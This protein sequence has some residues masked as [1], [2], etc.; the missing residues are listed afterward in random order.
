MAHILGISG[1]PRRLGITERML[2]RA[3]DGARSA[4]AGVEKIILNEL[5]FKPCQECG[6]CTETGACEL[7]DD[8]KGVYKKFDE[9]DGFIIAS[10]I[11]FGS[12]S[13][14]LKMMI[15]R[16]Q[17]A[18]ARKYVLKAPPPYKKRR[19][20][21]FICVGGQDTKEYFENAKQIVKLMFGTLDIDYLNDIFVG[22]CNVKAKNKP[23]SDLAP[24]KAFELGKALAEACLTQT[25]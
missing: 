3:L 24:D 16:F 14:Q 12:V 11:F 25:R 23:K 19:K 7:E 5:D 4:G 22:G 20:G 17:S 13:A 2:D 18:W 21:I 8:M 15:D 10:P 1:S 6:D 9:A